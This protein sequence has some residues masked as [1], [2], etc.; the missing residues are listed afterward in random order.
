M[1]TA[2]SSTPSKDLLGSFGAFSFSVVWLCLT[3]LYVNLSPPQDPSHIRDNRSPYPRHRIS[4][5]RRRIRRR[6]RLCLVSLLHT[7]RYVFLIHN[8]SSWKVT[9]ALLSHKL[10]ASPRI[11][12]PSQL[13]VLPYL[14][15]V[16]HVI[17]V[18]RLLLR[19]TI[20]TTMI[21]MC[22]FGIDVM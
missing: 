11:G 14:L 9:I 13:V 10:P 5:Q 3:S 15:F 6:A 17:Y 21:V 1:C 8:Q 12:Y 20:S 18:V 16:L 22:L 2:L 4:A 7:H 19:F